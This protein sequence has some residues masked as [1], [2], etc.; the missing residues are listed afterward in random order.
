MTVIISLC[1]VFPHTFNAVEAQAG[2]FPDKPI[3]Y[4]ISYSAG[5]AT[6]TLIRALIVP[7][8]KELGQPIIVINKPGG[9]ALLGTVEILHSKPD[10][11]TIG[12]FAGT[13]AL[14]APHTPQCPY[15]TIDGL[16]PIINYGKWVYPVI[17]KNDAPWKTWKDF[18]AYAKKGSRN[19]TVSLPGSKSQTPQGLAMWGMEKKE[20]IKLTYLTAKGAGEQVSSVLGGHADMACPVMTATIVQY[21]QDGSLRYLAFLGS[22]K[23]TGYEDIPSFPE[24][25]G[26]VEALGYVGIWGPAGIPDD[27]LHKLEYAFT[28]GIMDPK[29]VELMGNMNLPLAYMSQE[30]IEKDL[31]H[32]FPIMGQEVKE[33]M[34]IESK[35]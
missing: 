6:D 17:V 32:W 20:G 25:Y 18:V 10:G 16:Q 26:D 11:Y 34:E 24:L 31:K 21:I 27:R 19:I 3:N 2:D 13:Q 8:S 23:S 29:F 14:I 33:L 30:E 5:G 9:G 7:V 4:I 15:K 28:R 12:S 22:Q 1:L 35:N